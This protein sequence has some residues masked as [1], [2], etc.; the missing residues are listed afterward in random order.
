VVVLPETDAA[1]GAALAQRLGATIRRPPMSVTARRVPAGRN[2]QV[3][4]LR[5]PVSVSIG[6]AV[7][8]DHGLTA[9]A[10]LGAADDALYAAK[11]AGRDT[12]RIAQ[13]PAGS[14]DP[15]NAVLAE[16][17]GPGSAGTAGLAG[18]NRVLVLPTS[19][20]SGN[21]Q[22]PPHPRGR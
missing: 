19:G 12:Y 18:D 2:S 6:I 7:F 4:A 8:P 21:P 5:V 17:A 15:V 14:D 1:G 20:G 9:A 3:R 10:V 16:G 13:P 22:A 11:A